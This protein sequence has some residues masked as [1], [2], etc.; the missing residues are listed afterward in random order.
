MWAISWQETGGRDQAECAK[1][2]RC[3]A[4]R[5]GRGDEDTRRRQRCVSALAHRCPPELHGGCPSDCRCL[6]FQSRL[7]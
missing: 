5:P 4:K 3:S 2:R 7:T 1:L 6:F